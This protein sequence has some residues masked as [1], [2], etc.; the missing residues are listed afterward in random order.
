MFV[1]ERVTGLFNVVD[2]DV[3]TERVT[4]LLNDVDGDVEIGTFAFIDSRF[5]FSLIKV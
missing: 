3:A 5:Q 4:G 2:G 1:V